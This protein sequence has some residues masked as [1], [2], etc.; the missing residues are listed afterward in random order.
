L[1]RKDDDTGWLRFNLDGT[2]QNCSNQKKKFS[3]Q[4]QDL[5]EVK[6]LLQQILRRLDYI[7]V[8]ISPPN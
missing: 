5:A 8:Q 7:E 6:S 3:K 1:K 2:E 4:S